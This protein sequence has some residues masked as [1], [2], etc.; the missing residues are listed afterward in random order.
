M[1]PRIL[2]GLNL[3]TPIVSE[4]VSHLENPLLEEDTYNGRLFH[5]SLPKAGE[6]NCTW[7]KQELDGKSIC[8]EGDIDPAERDDLHIPDIFKD[9][10]RE[11]GQVA[12]IKNTKEFH[13]EGLNGIIGYLSHNESS[14]VK[15]DNEEVLILDQKKTRFLIFED[16]GKAF[17]LIITNRDTMDT[18]YELLQ[19]VLVELGFVVDEIGISHSGFESI[20]DN[21][22]DTHLMTSVEDYEE[23]SIHKKHIVGRGY[24]DAEEYEREKR[25][26]TIHGQRFGTSQLDANSKTIQIS[27]DCLIRSYHK[28]T[29]SMYL[30]MILSYIIPSLSLTIQTSVTGYDSENSRVQ[31]DQ[32]SDD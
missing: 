8:L 5:V 27:Q 25:Q 18:L 29:L 16:S 30:S 20:A 12:S 9:G 15:F 32:T 11:N 26:G 10:I 24:G 3:Y 21:L 17:L 23:A 28:L 4:N 1:L 19:D 22:I 14:T 2:N 13:R 7:L 31:L 6:L